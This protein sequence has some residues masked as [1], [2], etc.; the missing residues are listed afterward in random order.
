[1]LYDIFVNKLIPCVYNLGIN[2]IVL[3]RQYWN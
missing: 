3:N 1:M 2:A